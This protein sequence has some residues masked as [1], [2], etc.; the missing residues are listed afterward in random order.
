[1]TLLGKHDFNVSDL[2]TMLQQHTRAEDYFGLNVAGISEH[3][4]GTKLYANVVMLGIAFQKG[5]LPLSLENIEWGLKET[6][7]SAAADNLKAFHLGRKLVFEPELIHKHELHET[8]EQF[9]AERMDV[10]K[11]NH[12]TGRR[13]ALDFA[14]LVRRSEQS[15]DLG[16]K[17]ARDIVWRLYDLVEFGTG[18]YARRYLDLVERV[19]AQ[20]S[21]EHGFAATKAVIWNLHKAMIIKDEVYV[22]HLLTSEEKTRRDQHRYHVD[23]ARGDKLVYH[24]LNRPEFNVLGRDIRFKFSPKKWHLNLLKHFRW[25]RRVMPAWH[26]REREFRD[27]YISLVENFPNAD[28]RAAY[29]RYVQ[30][31]RCVE[32]V[33]GY[34]EIRYPKMDRAKR[35]VESLLNP[36]V[37]PAAK[38]SV[39]V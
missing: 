3:F 25:L 28:G 7:G 10:L 37:P 32:E 19:Y 24:H 27:W 39:L 11:R 5:L 20:D 14:Q 18:D 35:K 38:Q 1:M 2:E 12:R 15:I 13:W 9:V 16:E 6:M 29:D 8:Y 30:A 26:R 33:K 34:R 4:F 23:P 36:T 31:L 17:V 22:A 21:A